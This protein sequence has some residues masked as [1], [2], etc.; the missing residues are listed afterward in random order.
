MLS[1]EAAMVY[2]NSTEIHLP[3]ILNLNFLALFGQF[4]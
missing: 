2:M 1:M 4:W 3:H